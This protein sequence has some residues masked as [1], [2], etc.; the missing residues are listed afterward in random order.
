MNQAVV[1]SEVFRLPSPAPSPQALACDGEHLWLG[2]TE[3]NRIY[4]IDRAHFTVF[5][6]AD[7]K[8]G[9]IGAVC[10]GDELRLV[11]SNDDE[12][13]RVIR[14]FVPGHGVKD[15]E[16]LHCPNDTGS[17]LA[18]DGTFL[19][20]TH[21]VDK[22]LLQLDASGKA[23]Q[24]I[25]LELD[26]RSLA[27]IAFVGGSLFVSVRNHDNVSGFLIRM[28]TLEDGSYE[29]LADIPFRAVSLTHDG[30]RF[31]TSDKTKNELVAFEV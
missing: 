19:W 4:G 26:G 15:S 11:N 29:R 13:N 16:L 18:F 8:G 24:T 10:V 27:G 9:P 31:W 17:Y 21:A 30:A 2:S 3:T 5:E 1:I 23:L 6:E 25:A 20:L 28:T 14:R 12:D 7:A 22:R